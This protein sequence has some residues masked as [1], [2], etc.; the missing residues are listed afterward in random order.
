[1]KLFEMIDWNTLAGTPRRYKSATISFT[2]GIDGEATQEEIQGEIEDLK[3]KI[4]EIVEDAIEDRTT[5]ITG[6]Q[7]NETTR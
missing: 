6:I 3:E 1:M 5:L 2:I 4:K 7:F